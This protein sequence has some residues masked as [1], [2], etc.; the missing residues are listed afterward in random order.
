M[1]ETYTFNKNELQTA[2]EFS[3]NFYRSSFKQTDGVYIEPQTSGTMNLYASNSGDWLYC[4][5]LNELTGDSRKKPF[6]ICSESVIALHKYM[7]VL[8]KKLQSIP[9]KVNFGTEEICRYEVK[10]L[11]EIRPTEKSVFRF[12]LGQIFS[13]L[14]QANGWEWKNRFENFTPASSVLVQ[15]KELYT[16]TGKSKDFKLRFYQSVNNSKMI[17]L[18]GKNATSSL[19][20]INGEVDLQFHR[21]TLRKCL[22][23]FWRKNLTIEIAF[24]EDFNQARFTCK[25]S[26]ITI[27]SVTGNDWGDCYR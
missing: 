14:E 21:Q 26:G 15:P 27:H 20:T 17:F 1:I 3:R 24:T 23:P 11:A 8:D 18:A 19:A 13:I 4:Q 5:K 7:K 2:L 22:Q 9:L 12:A 16:F 10:G 25:E 6:A